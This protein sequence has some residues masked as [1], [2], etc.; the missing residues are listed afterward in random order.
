LD[1]FLILWG[2]IKGKGM[3]SQKVEKRL[4][5][6]GITFYKLILRDSIP[7][8]NTGIFLLIPQCIWETGIKNTVEINRNID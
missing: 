5:T 2:R 4:R 1:L 8:R 7:R 3:C 6:S